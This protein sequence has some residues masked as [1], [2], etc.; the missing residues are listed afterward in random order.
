MYSRK[1]K[2]RKNKEG[3]KKLKGKKGKEK[4][5]CKVLFISI[6]ERPTFIT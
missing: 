1:E 6:E 5:N 4:K 2:K 3:N